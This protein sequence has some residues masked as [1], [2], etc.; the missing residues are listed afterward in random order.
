MRSIRF[1]IAKNA[2]VNVMRG[3]ASAVVAVV[4]PHFLTRSLGAD[5]FAGWALMLQVA[6]YANYLDFG[7]QT[8]VARFLAA[9]IE[10]RDYERC[11]QVLSTAVAILTIGGGIAAFGL[12]FTALQLPNL[13]RS[14]P[15]SLAGEVSTG[16][17]ILAASS[18]ISL[19][20]SAYSGVLIGL[21][22]NE[23][24]AI[25]IALS[26]VLGAVAVL[27]TA[28]WTASLVW[29]SFWIAGFN[30]L[31][32]LVQYGTV[33]KLLPSLRF[34]IASINRT[35][36]SELV[37][38]CATLS[39]WSFS[40]LLISGLDVTIVGLF[41]FHAVGA[42]SIAATLI[43]F[44]T[45][46]VSAGYS[47]MLAPIAVLQARHDYAC[48]SRLII[49]TTCLNTYFSVAVIALTFLFGDKLVRAWVGTGYLPST[50]P[51]L[52]ILLIAQA[53]RLVGSAYG[54]ALV[55]LGLQR[56]G[57]MPAIVEGVINLT[58]SI[59]GMAVI[60]P[61]GVAGATLIAAVIAVSM[62]VVSILPR[63]GE[64]RISR[65]RFLGSGVLAPMVAALPLCIWLLGRPWVEEMC[66]RVSMCSTIVVLLVL[67]IT[68]LMIWTGI[69]RVFHDTPSHAVDQKL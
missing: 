53:I 23:F 9:S 31:A 7:L 10:L 12:A 41:D 17:V 52:K 63:I 28:H 55:G 3:G 69:R 24:P 50:L 54:T 48:I 57:I 61:I 42:Y 6:A 38:Y 22:R 30:L 11:N 33:K 67:S 14:V 40:M 56:H 13:F 35:M 60:G 39:V 29:L 51:V 59:L 20:L 37:R 36:T 45:G 15:H 68:A 49:K 25:I 66:R 46:L 64:I 32:S 16:I 58:L 44:F 62:V 4:L 47:A 5:R 8:A 19:P 2:F 26:R 65:S 27:M 21:Q 43:M 34:S 1:T 18:A